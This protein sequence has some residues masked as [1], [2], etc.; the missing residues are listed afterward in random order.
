MPCLQL[1]HSKDTLLIQRNGLQAREA[2]LTERETAIS[3]RER[4]LAD[5]EQQL[6][7]R[8]RGI[9]AERD[10]LRDER[11]RLIAVLQPPVEYDDQSDGEID[12]PTCIR[13]SEDRENVPPLPSRPSLDVGKI[14]SRPS[15]VPRRPL[16]ERRSMCARHCCGSPVN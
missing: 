1:A 11:A 9:R 13:L 6:L 15:L 14:A 4:Q 8:E 5:R 12:S 2:A 3:E 16:E 7:E 10:Q